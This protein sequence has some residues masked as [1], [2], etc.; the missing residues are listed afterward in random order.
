MNR[1][2][3]SCAAVIPD[4]ASSCPSCGRV[5]TASVGRGVAAAPAVA[6]HA[7]LRD[8]VVGALAYLTI[9]PAIVL[10]LVEP[11]KQNRFVR[12][13]ALQCVFAAV[14]SVVVATALL[15]L[16]LISW[17]NL[18]LIPI[19]IVVFL[20]V[21]ILMCVCMVKA[22]QGQMLKLPVI[23]DLADKALGRPSADQ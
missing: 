12:F 13:H 11:Y 2:C 8:S 20:G 6:P 23:G 21:L 15:L 10:L 1:S 5:C 7:V 4:G 9:V 16:G 22:Y 3:S 14:A 19:W 18:L 17:L